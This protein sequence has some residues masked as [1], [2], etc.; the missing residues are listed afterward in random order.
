M[1]GRSYVRRRK[2]RQWLLVAVCVTVFFGPAI[3]VRLLRQ[4]EPVATP[5]RYYPV[6]NTPPCYVPHYGTDQA[7]TDWCRTPPFDYIKL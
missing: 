6:P 7:G 4:S 1:L 2:Q 5:L 3:A